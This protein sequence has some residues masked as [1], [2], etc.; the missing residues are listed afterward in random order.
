M[1]KTSPSPSKGSSSSKKGGSS[2]KGKSKTR[3]R[4]PKGYFVRAAK[5]R[6]AYH[7]TTVPTEDD[8]SSAAAPFDDVASNAGD[9]EPADGF[10]AEGGAVVEETVSDTEVDLVSNDDDEN[11]AA[12]HDVSTSG[13]GDSNDDSDADQHVG[14]GGQGPPVD[15]QVPPVDPRSSMKQV[16]PVGPAR[17]NQAST[18][19]AGQAPPVLNTPQNVSGFPATD[20]G[21]SLIV[22]R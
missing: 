5:Y 11:H 12:R 10:V 16:S 6:A 15:E 13:S 20:G 14:G 8:P 1:A 2:G 22:I 21:K 4:R 7:A 17:K 19:L 18:P 3:S 9:S